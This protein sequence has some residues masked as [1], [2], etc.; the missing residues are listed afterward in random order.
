MAFVPLLGL[1]PFVFYHLF[2]KDNLFKV[3]FCS[4]IFLGSIPTCF[5]LYFSFRKFGIIGI[6]ALFDFAKN[7]A[8]GEVGFNNL[9]L[10]PLNFIYLT[11]PI[12]I[13]LIILF[14]FTRSNINI[15]Y[16]L[17][18]YCYP[19][20]SLILLLS[21]STS[22]PHYYLFLLPSLSIIFSTY[23]VSNSFRYSFS[24]STIRYLIFLLFLAVISTILFSIINYK[25]F[26]FQYSYGNPLVV[27][28]LLSF[29]LLSYFTSIRY[30]FNIN[31]LSIN[32][33]NFFYNLIIPQ[34]IS[35]SL[36]F[37]FGILGNPNYETKVFLKD[38]VV[39]S[40]INSNT[41][42]LFSLD[43][44][45]KTLLSYYLPSS[46]IVDDF[47]EISKYKYLIT[48]NF[49]SLEKYDVIKS[50]VPLKKFDNHFLLMNISK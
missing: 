43:S 44:K 15:K 36:L 40:I 9:I 29:I 22:Y 47:D 10:L 46:I 45:T 11:F 6:T 50:F 35:L 48:S 41:I 38:E 16:P 4:G 27:Y 12:G 23:L 21:M 31:Q 17:L 42:Y 19:L 32:L 25:D 39:S 13:L 33:I 5:N 3:S 37:N 14:I 30:L 8:L 1:S 49:Y 20:L 28:I 26:V 7:K 24:K 2:R 18:I 34:Y